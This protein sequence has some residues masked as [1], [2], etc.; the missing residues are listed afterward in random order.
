LAILAF[1]TVFAGILIASPV[2]GLRPIRALRCCFTSFTIPGSTNS[3]DLF[4]S[5]SASVV[6]SSKNSRA[7]VRFTSNRSAKCEKSSDLPILRA[8][9]IGVPLT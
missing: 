2:A 9:A 6:S 5:F 8:S 7:W 1:T 3:P 4:N